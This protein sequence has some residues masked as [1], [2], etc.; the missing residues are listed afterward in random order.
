MKAKVFCVVGNENWGK[1][2]TLYYLVGESRHRGWI[3]LNNIDLFVRHMSNDDLPD[4]FINFV[5]ALESENKPYV[6]LALCPSFAKEE[7]QTEYILSTLRQ[8]G[9]ELYFWVLHGQYGSSEAVSASDIETLRKYGEVNLYKEKSE[10]PKRAE[11]LKKYISK[12]LK[13]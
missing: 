2:E 11:A 9:Y 4:S 7:A 1:S 5:A 12:T 13:I 10:A 6:I 3:K 8:K